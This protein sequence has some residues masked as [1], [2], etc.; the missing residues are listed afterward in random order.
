MNETYT[1]DAV[2]ILRYLVDELGDDA[3][4]VFRRA[5]ENDC[6]IELPSV[7]AAEVLYRIDDGGAVKGHELTAS[8][9]E[10][11]EGY[12]TFLPVTVVGTDVEQLGEMTRLPDGLTLHDVVVVASHCVRETKAVLTTDTE[13]D[14]TGVDVVW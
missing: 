7:A 14:E 4:A 2:G 9:E 1:T 6:V 3:D 13:I 10:V 8:A 5:E 11:A 12:A